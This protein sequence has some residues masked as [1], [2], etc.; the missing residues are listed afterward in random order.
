MNL[1][2]FGTTADL[3]DDEVLMAL[4][5]VFYYFSSEKSSASSAPFAVIRPTI[6]QQRPQ[7]RRK[8]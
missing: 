3:M 7:K 4:K 6:K 8:H 2:F 5:C 1:K